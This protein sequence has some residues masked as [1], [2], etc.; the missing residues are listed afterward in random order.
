MN[1]VRAENEI[2][3]MIVQ[4]KKLDKATISSSVKVVLE[5]LVGFKQCLLEYRKARDLYLQ[6]L[7][8]T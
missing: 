1:T 3:T 4:A 6:D 5:Q 8:N 7:T 2:S